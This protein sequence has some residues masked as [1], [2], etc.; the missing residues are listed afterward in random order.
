MDSDEG[1]DVIPVPWGR[2]KAWIE[3]QEKAEQSGYN[4]NPPTKV[5]VAALSHLVDFMDEPE[6]TPKSIGKLDYV[7][8]LMQL[9]QSKSVAP[10]MFR[11]LA[12]IEVPV[13]G[14]LLQRWRTVC[15]LPFANNKEFPCPGYGLREGKQPPLSKSKKLSK[16]YAAKYAFLYAKNHFGA[17]TSSNGGAPV[18]TNTSPPARNPTP[19]SNHNNNNNNN[20][21][22]S[23]GHTSPAK[24]QAPSGGAPLSPSSTLPSPSSSTGDLT[25]GGS[26]AA[27][28]TDFYDS[29]TLPSLLDQVKKETKI[30][31]LGYPIF[32]IFPDPETPGMYAGK[33][34]FK[35][36]SRIPE[37]LGYIK[38][39]LTKAL[40]KELVAEEIL[41]YCKAQRK[42]LEGL[43]NT[44]NP[45]E[46]E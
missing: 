14:V 46:K 9:A 20:N 31:K 32:D 8:E 33:P 2:L 17:S 23:V 38:G 10:P 35:N 45:L 15:T 12:P 42:R 4:P 34:I 19:D 3:A 26:S 25:N 1:V 29:K 39:A 41:Q 22:V 40:A 28:D 30:L 7:S 44:F 11:D 21:N 43:M 13:G 16:Q 37:G 36:N 6:P 24:V 27:E 5:Q 18:A